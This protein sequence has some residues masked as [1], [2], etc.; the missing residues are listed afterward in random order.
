MLCLVCGQSFYKALAMFE[1]AFDISS[2]ANSGVIFHSNIISI[3]LRHYAF[4][5]HFQHLGS[6]Y[7]IVHFFRFYINEFKLV[8]KQTIMNETVKCVIIRCK[9]IM[10]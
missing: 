3:S 5:E 8:L 2:C 4:T 7:F 1:K 9:I 6:L 10:E